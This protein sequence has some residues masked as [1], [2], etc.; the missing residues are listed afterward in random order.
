MCKVTYLGTL[1]AVAAEGI[2]HL[3]GGGLL[4]LQTEDARQQNG[5]L[6]SEDGY[7]PRA[8]PRSQQSLRFP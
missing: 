4:A 7:S 2:T 8:A 3:L 6:S 5:T 1:V